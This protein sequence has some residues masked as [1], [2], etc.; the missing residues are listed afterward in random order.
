VDHNP[1][2]IPIYGARYKLFRY[3]KVKIPRIKIR[4]NL[5]TSELRF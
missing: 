3:H 5:N 2:A 4:C 1:K